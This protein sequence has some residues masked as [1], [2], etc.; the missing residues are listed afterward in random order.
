M[1][2]KALDEMRKSLDELG[3]YPGPVPNDKIAYIAQIHALRAM[4]DVL[5]RIANRQ[6]KADGH[7]TEMVGALHSMD[8]RLDRIEN[9]SLE[10]DVT[11]NRIRIDDLDNRVTQLEMKEERRTG[12]L[13]FANW[14]LKNWPGIIGFIA[15]CALVLVAT[16]KVSL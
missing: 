5:E 7:L 6:D 4:S 8:K 12:A 3:T 1:P 9:N 10:R 13:S 2:R 15:M 16:G 14:M 11:S